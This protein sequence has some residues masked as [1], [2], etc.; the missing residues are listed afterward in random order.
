[1]KFLDFRYKEENLGSWNKKLEKRRYY[2][3]LDKCKSKKLITVDKLLW[4]KIQNDYLANLSNKSS[5]G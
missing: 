5:L 2:Y 4:K 3:R 1:M